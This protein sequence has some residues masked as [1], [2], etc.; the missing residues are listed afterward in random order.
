MKRKRRVRKVLGKEEE[1]GKGTLLRRE[2]GRERL[3]VNGE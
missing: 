3:K 2:G 1:Y